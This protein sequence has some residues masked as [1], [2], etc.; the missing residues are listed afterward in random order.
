MYA[1]YVLLKILP[2]SSDAQTILPVKRN[3]RFSDVQSCGFTF[4]QD[5]PEEN[6][7]GRY[8]ESDDYISHTD[9]AK[10]FSNKLYRLARKIMLTTEKRYL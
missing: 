4:T 8:Y 5:Y 1:L 10:G 3:S 6:E 2:Y 7:I 9:T